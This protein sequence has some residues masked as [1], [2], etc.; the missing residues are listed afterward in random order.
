MVK[1][2]QK[3]KYNFFVLVREDLADAVIVVAAAPE[4]ASRGALQATKVS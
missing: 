2:R 1:A 3:L 4:G